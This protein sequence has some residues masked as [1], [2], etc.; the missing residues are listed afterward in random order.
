MFCIVLY[1]GIAKRSDLGL[2]VLS[3]SKKRGIFVL[4]VSINFCLMNEVVSWS[5]TSS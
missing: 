3:S 5:K 2:K 1:R 4:S